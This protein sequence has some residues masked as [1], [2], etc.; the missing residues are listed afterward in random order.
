[1][2]SQ[3]LGIWELRRLITN[4]SMIRILWITIQIFSYNWDSTYHFC[5]HNHS[6][7]SLQNTLKD[8]I[9][10]MF[11]SRFL[12]EYYRIPIIIPL[13]FLTEFSHDFIRILS[14]YP[15]KASL[16]IGNHSG[17][18]FAFSQNSPPNPLRLHIR[19]LSWF[20]SEFPGFSSE[21]SKESH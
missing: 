20:T 16:K 3:T 13:G 5:H 12:S 7:D 2:K 10:L 9:Q 21:S 15:L 1:M 8:L 6:S 4:H 14:R 11:L 17:L 18:S 19:I